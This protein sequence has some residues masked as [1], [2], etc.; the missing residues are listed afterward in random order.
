MAKSKSLVLMTASQNQ[1]PADSKTSLFEEPQ[2]CNP[3]SPEFAENSLG[4][5][6]EVL[7][8]ASNKS[9]PNVDG[10]EEDDAYLFVIDDF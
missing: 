3:L 6:G 5:D 9:S 8:T 10:K 1:N 4:Q 7:S 2:Q